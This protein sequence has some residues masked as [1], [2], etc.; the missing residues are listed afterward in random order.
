MK[1]YCDGSR[2]GKSD[3]YFIGWAAVCNMGV[4]SFGSKVGGSNINA[5]MFAIHDC[6]K[7]ITTYRSVWM[8]QWAE[9]GEVLEIVTDSLT[10]LQ[11][12]NGFLKAP[13][14][15]DLDESLNYQI[16][17]RIVKMLDKL[18]QNGIE[19][20]LKHVRGHGRDPNM[21]QEDQIGNAFA[22]H[23]ATTQAENLKSANK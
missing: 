5:E 22:D 18:Q 3:E 12:I 7:N 2:V 15:Y 9:S 21:S 8:K 20:E 16:A 14:E 13:Q 17:E 1:I 10:S 19:W 6:L 4:V 23:V 11:I